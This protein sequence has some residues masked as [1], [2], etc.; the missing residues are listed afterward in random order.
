MAE[1]GR[2]R[3]ARPGEAAALT[4]LALRS[5]AYWPYDDAFMAVMRRVLKITEEEIRA[6]HVLVHETG[7]V[8]DGVGA[9]ALFD[10]DWEVDHL[11]VEPAAIGRGIGRRLLDALLARAARLGAGRV[12]VEADPHAESFYARRGG[13]RVGERAS[14]MIDGRSLPVLAIHLDAG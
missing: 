3:R 13:V 1:R 8:V 2:I 12:L 5:K 6:H 7:G 14:G 11:W 9:L 10:D 4:E